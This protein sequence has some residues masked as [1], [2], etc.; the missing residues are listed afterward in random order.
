MNPDLEFFLESAFDPIQPT[1]SSIG[2]VVVEPDYDVDP[3]GDPSQLTAELVDYLRTVSPDPAA[4]ATHD[5]YEVSVPSQYKG[6][7]KYIRTITLHADGVEGAWIE[8]A[9]PGNWI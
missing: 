1:S 9:P 3:E 6:L 8:V 2:R 4:L 7:S 5:G